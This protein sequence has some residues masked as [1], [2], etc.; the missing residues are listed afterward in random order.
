[1]QRYADE[2]YAKEAQNT[3]LKQENDN[4]KSEL[5][6]A[7]QKHKVGIHAL[8]DTSSFNAAACQVAHAI[9][10]QGTSLEL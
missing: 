2:L 5:A 6:T 1:M 9:T 3:A 8:D 10:I 4:L 7:W